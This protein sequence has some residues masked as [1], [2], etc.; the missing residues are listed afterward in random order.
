MV[1][2]QVN[3]QDT[4]IVND[5][6]GYLLK[7][8]RRQGMNTDIRRSIFVILMSSDVG[9]HFVYHLFLMNAQDYVDACE[10]FSQ[11]NLTEIQQREII[12]VLLHSCGN[13]M[14]FCSSLSL[15]LIN[16]WNRRK[17]TIRTMPLSASNCVDGLIP[18]QSHCSSACGIFYE[19]WA[20]SQL[21]EQRWSRTRRVTMLVS[22]RYQA[23]ECAM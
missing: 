19:I 20:K 13:V 9:H 23:H 11:L 15:L 22:R 7:L 8:A 16:N 17:H 2:M 10:R 21:V 1:D 6:T 3:G 5:T 14:H 12:R 18:I 4:K